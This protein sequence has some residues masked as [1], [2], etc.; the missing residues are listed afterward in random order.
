[1][2]GPQRPTSGLPT[3]RTTTTRTQPTTR[4]FGSTVGEKPPS[5]S[6]AVPTR[7]STATSRATKSPGE[8]SS[9]TAKKR[10]RDYEREINEDTSIHVVVRCR[11]RN[12]RELK[13]NS[14]VVVST[15]GVKGKNVELSM[16]PNALSDK[17][18]T[19][20][21]VFSAAAD[22]V[23]VYDDIVLPIV[24][25]V[26]ILYQDFDSCTNEP[27]AGWIQ[28]HDFRIRTDRHRKDLHHVRRH[29]RH[30]GNTL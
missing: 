27:D 5:R 3:R 11:G 8:P 29:D 9:I 10:E 6:P 23:T 4:R 1:M 20:D 28:L 13:E 17:T 22:Q 30:A 19:F 18:Y 15:E 2:P 24:N 26:R 25:E 12:D 21:K 7:A 16:G 14:G